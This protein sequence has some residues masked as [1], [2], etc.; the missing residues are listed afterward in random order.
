MRVV[1]LGNDREQFGVY[2]RERIEEAIVKRH[3]A[4]G[5]LFGAFFGKD[6]FR[7]AMEA[8]ITESLY[9]RVRRQSQAG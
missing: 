3:Q 6:G 8:W 1:A 7:E 5:E 2:L 4:N 9:E